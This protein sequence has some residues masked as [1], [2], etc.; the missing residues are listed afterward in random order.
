VRKE[1]QGGMGRMGRM[2]RMGKGEEEVAGR[3]WEG[4]FVCLIDSNCC[5]YWKR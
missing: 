4:G 5:Y 2:G 3:N 1:E